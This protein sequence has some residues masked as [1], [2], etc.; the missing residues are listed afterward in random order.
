MSLRHYL[1]L[2]AALGVGLAIAL[3]GAQIAN[4]SH[5]RANQLS[6]HQDT[7]NT[8]EF[9]LTGSWRCTFFFVAPCSASIGDTFSAGSMTPGDG[10]S[11]FPTMTVTGVDVVND[12]VTAEAHISHTYS[13]PG[14][15][16]A[17]VSDCCRLSSFNGHMNNGDGAVRYETL[18]DLSQTSAGP[19]ALVAPIVDCPINALC[20]FTVP[21]ADAD[22]QGLRWRFSTD[23]E[24]SG[25][26]GGFVQPAGATI[27]ATN[28]LYQWNTTGAA[29]APSG[30]TFYSTQVMVENVVSGVVISRTAVD[31]FIRLGSGSTNAQPVFIA[32]T[33]ADGSV[34]NGT[35][36]SPLT[37]DVAASD[38]DAGD[39]V[40]LGMLGQPAGSL[41]APTSGNPATGT[42]NW[43]PA[44]PGDYLI[45]LIATDQKGLGAVPRGIILRIGTTPT[46]AAPQF[47]AP[48]PADGSVI[49]GT[50]GS[51]LSFSVAATDADA[52]DTVTLGMGGQPAG[53]SFSPTAG[54]PA[55]GT[56]SWT[57]AAPGDYVVTL[58][59]ADQHGATA[60]P[61]TVTLRIAPAPTGLIVTG[62]G[63]FNTRDGQVTFALSNDTVSMVKSRGTPFTF[64]GDVDSVT[65]SGNTAT[66]TGTGMYK[67]VAGYTF[68]ITVVDQGSAGKK[69]RDT[70]AVVI[71]NPSGA[72]V[73]STSRPEGMKPGEIVITNTPS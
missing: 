29:L 34:I 19:V 65:G 9:H 8:V 25:S 18:V 53:S 38:P 35:V 68:S 22:G 51:P 31:F 40:T 46:N 41:F 14:P 27:N 32:P 7:G 42:F 30:D 47:V 28:G 12:V 44:A 26:P 57:P 5:Y 66:L 4:A 2:A 63:N 60:T 20:S 15:W 21:A 11:I 55:T 58:T 64:D 69:Q 24:A 62:Q 6:W 56:F 71:R 17:S 48:T 73:F 43:T 39:V 36:G 13:G 23:V 70:I 37:F 3:S 49:N 54:N 61:R 67:G 33:P 72:I 16:T 52:G 59:A 50:A 1:A 10:S 45:T